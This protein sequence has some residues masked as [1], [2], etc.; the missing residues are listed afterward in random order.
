MEW[1]RVKNKMS[2]TASN[3]QVMASAKAPEALNRE[4]NKIKE[5]K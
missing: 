2:K 5:I 4:F 1:Q 3:Q